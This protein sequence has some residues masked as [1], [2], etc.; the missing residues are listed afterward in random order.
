[1]PG[2]Q[3]RGSV[4]L[5][6][7]FE[8]ND[9]Q[10]RNASAVLLEM[11]TG[12][13]TDLG[14]ACGGIEVRAKLMPGDTTAL[15]GS[16]EAALDEQPNPTHL[17][18]LGQAPG[19]NKVTLERYATNLRD[20]GTS[21]RHGNLPC[22]VPVI[23]G[24]PAAYRSTWPE[25]TRLIEA[26]NSFGIPAAMSNDAGNHLCNQLLYLA[27][28]AGAERSRT[29]VATFVHIPVLPQ[30]VIDE[31][32]LTMRHPNCPYLPLPMLMEA[33]EHLLR[34]AFLPSDMVQARPD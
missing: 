26:L 19:R 18:L 4:V 17:L 9:P 8:A 28:H 11:L 2:Q 14:C 32:P 20:F 10:Y 1:M 15:A 7:G 30:Q 21:D 3:A 33:V 29:Y 27:L 34:A 5:I 13:L 12:Q 24:G 22:D 16:L 23:D 31:E 25:Q 6:T